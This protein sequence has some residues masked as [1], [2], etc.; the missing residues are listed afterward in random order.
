MARSKRIAA[1][2]AD[3]DFQ[4]VV[5]QMGEQ[6][7]GKVMSPATSTEDREK[8]LAEYH[9]LKRLVASMNSWSQNKDES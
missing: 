3:E 6:M 8:T 1:I 4:F 5:A 9:A 2:L 7:T